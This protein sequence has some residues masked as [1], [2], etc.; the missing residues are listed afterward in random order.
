VKPLDRLFNRGPFPLS[1]DQDT[2]CQMAFAPG[3]PYKTTNWT[4]SFRQ[5]IDLGD[6]R[7]GLFGYPTGQSGHPASPHY[8][9]MIETWLEVKHFPL[10]F[11]RDQVE[12]ALEGKL[13]LKPE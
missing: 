1:G 12:A 11:E 7:T 13:K 5:I 4:P 2:V 9:D 6:T 3:K 10:L 8:A